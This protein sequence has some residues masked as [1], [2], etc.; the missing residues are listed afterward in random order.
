VLA[1]L[2]VALVLTC[3]FCVLYVLW[4]EMGLALMTTGIFFTLLGMMLFFEGNL[5]RI[6]NVSGIILTSTWT[7]SVR[8]VL[9]VFCSLSLA[10]SSMIL[11]LLVT[12]FFPHRDDTFSWTYA[13]ITVFYAAQAATG[14]SVISSW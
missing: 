9:T 10:Q 11:L 14:H 8:D 13:N 7:T 3:N 2:N 4:T 12:A 6:G 5:L 1:L